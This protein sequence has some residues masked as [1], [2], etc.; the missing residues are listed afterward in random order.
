MQRRTNEG[1]DGLHGGGRVLLLPR[2]RV[3]A[4]RVDVAPLQHAVLRR[5]GQGREGQGREGDKKG[6]GELG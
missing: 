1:P 5:E 4:E 6:V 3:V 2:K